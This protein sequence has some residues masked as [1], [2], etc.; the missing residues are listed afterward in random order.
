MTENI[1]TQ[2]VLVAEEDY[3]IDL[4]DWYDLT[5]AQRVKAQQDANNR[6][7]PFIFVQTWYVKKNEYAVQAELNELLGRSYKVLYEGEG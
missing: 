7:V 1:I 6:D 5:N 2:T 4:S 3:E